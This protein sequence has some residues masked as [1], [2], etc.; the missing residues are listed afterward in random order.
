MD[1]CFTRMTGGDTRF[2]EVVAE[3]DEAAAG[4]EESESRC[5]E[6]PADDGVE[7]KSRDEDDSDVVE[8]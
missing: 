4:V 1:G 2:P 8:A 5:E 3:A 6:D 7:R